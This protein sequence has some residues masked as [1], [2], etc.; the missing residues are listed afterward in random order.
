MRQS[1]AHFRLLGLSATPGNE[2][3]H[4]QVCTAGPGAWHSI[5]CSAWAAALAVYELEAL[6]ALFVRCNFSYL[7]PRLRTRVCDGV[8]PMQEVVRNL[9]IHHIE[10]KDESDPEINK[11]T[12]AKVQTATAAAE[13]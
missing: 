9:G 13:S 5:L 6:A 4:I 7:V 11:H 3:S 1:Q 2:H 10:F 12:F 8:Y